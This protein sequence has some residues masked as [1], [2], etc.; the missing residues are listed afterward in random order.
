MTK[1]CFHVVTH[2]N[3]ICRI[4]YQEMVG[5]FHKFVEQYP[6]PIAHLSFLLVECRR[7][8]RNLNEIRR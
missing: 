4:I 1:G 7:L 8:N 5:G 3:T 6:R 2:N